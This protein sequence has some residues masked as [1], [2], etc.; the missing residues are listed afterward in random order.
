MRHAHAAKMY[1]AHGAPYESQMQLFI[2][3]GN[4][5]IKWAVR[6]GKTW[7]HQG[8]LPTAHAQQLN[9][10]A[11]PPIEPIVWVS[12]VAG[13]TAA[14]HIST[15]CLAQG[16]QPRFIVAQAL[17]CGVRN[18][19]EIPA[20]LGCDRWAALI[21]AWQLQQRACLVVNCGTATTLD[22]LSAHGEF[23]GGLILPGIS[24][25]QSSLIG[26]TAQ[27]RTATGSFNSFARNTADALLSGAI[28]A[29]CGAIERQYTL[30]N[31]ADAPIVLTGGA[32]HTAYDSPQPTRVRGG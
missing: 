6:S 10:A 25:M 29:S 23:L 7:L 3:A 4:T 17:Q 30:L 24:L 15:A 2:D 20:Q 27:L 18:A 26:A 19:Y 22:A 32:A 28:Q 14:Q 8:A 11:L 1:R 12:N 13:S 9:F 21:A 31:Q 5:R 16:W